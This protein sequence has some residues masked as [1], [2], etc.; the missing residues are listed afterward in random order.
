MN[1]KEKLLKTLI[2]NKSVPNNYHKKDGYFDLS[3]I[4]ISSDGSNLEKVRNREYDFVFDKNPTALKKIIFKDVNF[5]QSDFS[6]IT[7]VKCKFENCLFFK[8]KLKESRFFACEFVNC[9][10]DQT[11]FNGA[12]MGGRIGHHLGSYTNCHFRKA[13]LK[14]TN[15]NFPLLK[16]CFFEN[17]DFYM[18]DFNGSRFESCK[19]EGLLDDVRFRGVGNDLSDSFLFWNRL[20]P[21]RYKNTMSNV[22]FSRATLTAVAFSHSIDISTCIWPIDDSQYLII[23]NHIEFFTSLNFVGWSKEE[24]EYALS[25][26]KWMFL[27]EEYSNQK[28]LFIDKNLLFEGRNEIF[29]EKLFHHFRNHLQYFLKG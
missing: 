25:T 3:S 14:N 27:R 21:H 5:T 16:G 4:K 13:N 11:N 19:F 8:T 28:A 12:T 22:D 29:V 1:E 2:K 23:P 26:I 18:V 7:F 10:F 17:C 6:E 15:Y 9:I 24:S 20:N